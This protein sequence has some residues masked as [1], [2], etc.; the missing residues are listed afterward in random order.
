MVPWWCYGDTIS[1][2]L[3]PYWK[4]ISSIHK[5]ILA[6]KIWHILYGP[7]ISVDDCQFFFQARTVNIDILNSGYFYGLT[8]FRFDKGVGASN[9]KGQPL[10]QIREIKIWLILMFSNM[11]RCY[12]DQMLYE[13]YF[14]TFWSGC[15]IRKF[16]AG[17]PRILFNI[18]EFEIRHFPL[19]G[20]LIKS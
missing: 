18:M 10:P 12:G 19:T 16:Q 7:W 2:S 13:V 9:L 1:D 4:S 8:S 3:S 17:T 15:Q 11:F 6:H 20:L 14:G 5:Q